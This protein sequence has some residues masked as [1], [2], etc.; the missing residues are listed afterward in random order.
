MS[1]GA[2]PP[3]E[4][5]VPAFPEGLRYLWEAF[6]QLAGT[7]QQGSPILFSE[8]EAYSRVMRNPLEP[9]EVEIIKRLDGVWFA[10][11]EENRRS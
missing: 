3:E 5:A 6:H 1:L 10:A 8:I 11:K 4:L 2:A 9:W 7:R